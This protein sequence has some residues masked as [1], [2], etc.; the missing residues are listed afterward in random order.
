MKTCQDGRKEGT[1]ML[2]LRCHR[3][4]LPPSGYPIHR[5]EVA[6]QSTRL[7]RLC[8]TVVY[9]AGKTRARCLQ[10]AV[11]I[12]GGQLNHCPPPMA[13]KLYMYILF[14]STTTPYHYTFYPIP[15]HSHTPPFCLWPYHAPPSVAMI[16]FLPA[17]CPT[18][19]CLPSWT[20]TRTTPPPPPP[21][22]VLMT[23]GCPGCWRWLW[24]R[25][26]L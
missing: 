8:D 2:A 12:V 23:G 18:P 7:P 21:V 24:C 26:L 1:I 19:A 10:H 3:T 6:D 25:Y 20:T 9:D 4:T 15:G 17:F 16:T 14:F 13:A 11:P 22:W 5:Q